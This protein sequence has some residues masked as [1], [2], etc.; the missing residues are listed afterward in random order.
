MNAQAL[1]HEGMMVDVYSKMKPDTFTSQFQTVLTAYYEDIKRVMRA[2][3]ESTVVKHKFEDQTCARRRRRCCCCRRRRRRRRCSQPR[4]P[5]G[6]GRS[7]H[8][9]RGG[10]STGPQPWGQERGRQ[11]AGWRG[12]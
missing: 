1:K 5:A 7:S 11:G 12:W 3:T 4:L 10:A 2:S 6:R 9:R 8:I